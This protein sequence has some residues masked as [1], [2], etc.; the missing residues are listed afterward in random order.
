M[1]S[2]GESLGVGGYLAPPLTLEAEG[3]LGTAASCLQPGVLS[4]QEGPGEKGGKLGQASATGPYVGKPTWENLE[5]SLRV[6]DTASSLFILTTITQK[7]RTGFCLAVHMTSHGHMPTDIT[8][9]VTQHHTLIW[10]TQTHKQ[11]PTQ[12][13]QCTHT[14]I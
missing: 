8:H 5:L 11:I 6:P 7:P 12:S 14:R 3:S 2:K 13:T 1:K 9:L 4:L 10:D